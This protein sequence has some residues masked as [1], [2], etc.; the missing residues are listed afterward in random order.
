MKPAFFVVAAC[1]MVLGL[2]SCGKDG[3]VASAGYNPTGL[4]P[5]DSRG[6]YVEDWADN[7]EQWKRVAANSPRTQPRPTP[8]VE[9]SLPVVAVNDQ[10]PANAVPLATP[11]PTRTVSHPAPTRQV[12]SVA[13]KPTPKPVVKPVAAKPKPK[14]VAVKPK[15]KAPATVRYTVKKG[16]TLYGIASRNKSS[17]AAIQRANGIKG[18]VIQPGKVLVIPR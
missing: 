6:N 2:S 13:P 11:P 4:G 15:P 7:P 9:D 3:A 17:V 10:P 16:D 12:A 14:P 8:R 18:S 1:A 5:F